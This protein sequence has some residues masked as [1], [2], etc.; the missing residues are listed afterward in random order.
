MHE[1]IK[2]FFVDAYP[3]SFPIAI[4]RSIITNMSGPWD[5]WVNFSFP[6]CGSPLW[7]G[8]TCCNLFNLY[9]DAWKQMIPMITSCPSCC[10]WAHGFV[11]S[12]ADSGWFTI[13]DVFA[14]DYLFW[15]HP[16]TTPITFPFISY[17]TDWD[18]NIFVFCPKWVFKSFIFLLLSLY[19][20]RE[21]ARD[22]ILLFHI[23]I[24]VL[25]W[26]VAPQ[27]ND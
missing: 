14:A 26:N 3:S 13:S 1:N 21:K 6:T 7:V 5:S 11:C 12:V 4:D 24:G 2:H 15:A 16:G 22:S 18:T 17:S 10:H 9:L 20:Y 25:L 27:A 19:I 8:I 23:K